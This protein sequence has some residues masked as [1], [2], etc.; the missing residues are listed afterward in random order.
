MR[1]LRAAALLCATSAL[2][3]S[4]CASASRTAGEPAQDPAE[5]AAAVATVNQ[6]FDAMR[7]RDTTT[8]RRLLHPELRIFVPSMR[9]GQPVVRTSGVEQF[10]GSVAS[11]QQTLDE[12]AIDPEVRIDG[13]LASVWTYYDFILGDEFSHCGIDALHLARTPDGW[14]IIGLAYT[15]RSTGC[16]AR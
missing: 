1:M 6:L 12:R 4:A 9:N 11:A 15:T 8:I 10:I 5:E 16:R 13:G 2:L 14:R 7:T 3:A